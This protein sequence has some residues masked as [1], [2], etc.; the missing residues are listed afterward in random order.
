MA[1]KYSHHAATRSLG[2]WLEAEGV[3]GITGIDTRMLT[4]RLREHGTMKGWL[5]AA[6]DDAARARTAHDRQSIALSAPHG[7]STPSRCKRQ[8]GSR[9]G[10]QPG[11]CFANS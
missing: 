6:K 2:A 11:T 10:A 1:S 7:G 9:L 3:P 5:V 4:R 8:C